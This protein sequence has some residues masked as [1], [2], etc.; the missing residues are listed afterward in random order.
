MA[1]MFPLLVKTWTDAEHVREDSLWWYSVPGL[2]QL[3][4]P[5]MSSPRESSPGT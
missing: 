2:L 1:I 4:V 3:P 5:P